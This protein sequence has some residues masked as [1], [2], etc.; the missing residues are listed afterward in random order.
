GRGAVNRLEH[1]APGSDVRGAGEADRASDLR[2]D[3]GKNVAVEVRHHDDVE[4]LGRVRQLGGADVDDPV[5]LLDVRVLRPDL[6]E[7]LVKEPVRDLHDV[8]FG[9]A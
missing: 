2:R 3:V 5:L 6:V 8:V 7:D 9:E 4:S 1:R